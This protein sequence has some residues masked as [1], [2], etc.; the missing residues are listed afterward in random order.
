[1]LFW[2]FYLLRYISPLTILALGLFVSVKLCSTG[3]MRSN[4]KRSAAGFS[5]FY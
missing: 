1:M 4:T 5:V 2:Y 3:H